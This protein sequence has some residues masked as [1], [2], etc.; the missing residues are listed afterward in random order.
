MY[1]RQ[2]DARIMQLVSS[3]ALN[4]PSGELPAGSIPII[5]GTRVSVLSSGFNGN[6]SSGDDNVQKVAQKLD[7]LNI[8]GGAQ[9]EKGEQGDP[10]PTGPRGLRRVAGIQGIQGIQGFQGIY[11]ITIYRSVA[12]GNAAPATP[13]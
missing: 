6:L 5:G 2:V 10:G 4:S 3:A 11:R 12:N 8:A 1:K 9:G 7:D 13:S